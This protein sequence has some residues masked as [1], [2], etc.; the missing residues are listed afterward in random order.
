[1]FIFKFI[2][3]SCQ[4]CVDEGCRDCG[5]F[6]DMLVDRYQSL[7]LALEYL[8]DVFDDCDDVDPIKTKVRLN[9]ASAFDTALDCFDDSIS[10]DLSVFDHEY[11]RGSLPDQ[12]DVDFFD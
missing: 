1:M 4:R 10:I 7:G 8:K 12:F 3:P 9:M 6:Y 11:D 5:L 2:C